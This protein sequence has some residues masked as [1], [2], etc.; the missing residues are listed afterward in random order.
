MKQ[1]VQRGPL[2]P[3][4]RAV[5]GVFG[6]LIALV[7]LLFVVMAIGDIAGGDAYES[8]AGVV[9]AL[10]LF[11]LATGACGGWMAWRNLRRVRH[12]TPETAEELEQRILSVARKLGGRVTVLEVASRCGVSIEE[13]KEALSRMSRHGVIEP[14]LTD[15]GVM[16]YTFSGFLSTPRR[17]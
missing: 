5:L 17:D 7:S 4:P 13:A 6:V 9:W 2:H 14:G 16:I 15:D 8:E 11:F 12:G 3:A 10:L 1:T